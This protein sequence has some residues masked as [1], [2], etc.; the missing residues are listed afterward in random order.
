MIEAVGRMKSIDATTLNT[1]KGMIHP[2]E[3]T[4]PCPLNLRVSLRDLRA[5]AFRSI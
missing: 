1:C 4:K 5:S 2:F 3:M